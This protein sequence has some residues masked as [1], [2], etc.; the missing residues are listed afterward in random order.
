VLI[1]ILYLKGVS[2]GDFE[3]RHRHALYQS[4]VDTHFDWG[5][6]QFLTK[7]IQADAVGCRSNRFSYRPALLRQHFDLSQL[8]EDLLGCVSPLGILKSSIWLEAVPQ[9][10]P[11]CGG[12]TNQAIAI[13][14]NP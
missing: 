4:G 12:Q 8:R 6:S 14:R 11:R 10:G 7:Q 13:R 3:E 9:G 1:P 2:T 5:A